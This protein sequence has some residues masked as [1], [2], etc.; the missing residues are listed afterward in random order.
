MNVETD[1]TVTR[2]KLSTLKIYEL[3]NSEQFY[4]Q[5]INIVNKY[6][7]TLQNQSLS[8]SG[9]KSSVSQC[10][11]EILEL[12]LNPKKVSQ[13]DKL[14][15]S[16]I[17]WQ[18]TEVQDL[19]FLSQKD[20]IDALIDDLDKKFKPL[21]GY[22]EKDQ[23]EFVDIFY[24]LIGRILNCMHEYLPLEDEIV[25][26]LDFVDLKDTYIVLKQKIKEFARRFK[27]IDEGNKAKFKEE[28]VKL[29]DLKTE[30]Y[31]ET[32][33]NL[34]HMWDRIEKQENFTL[35]PKIV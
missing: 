6:N 16:E 7:V 11:N 10:Y 27:M 21:A 9:L 33:I 2:Q 3:L 20:F 32:S 22:N 12:V 5:I 14:K 19:L 30:F 4:L 24:D 1:S 18:D 34:H 28:L 17:D 26:L 29:R 25:G 23:M 8:V 13:L 35:I 15:H 31:R